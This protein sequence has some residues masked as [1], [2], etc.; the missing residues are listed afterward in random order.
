MDDSVAS[1]IGMLEEL[2]DEQVSGDV[3]SLNGFKNNAVC[4]DCDGQ[5][6]SVYNVDEGIIRFRSI[7]DNVDDACYEVYNRLRFC[8][9]D[10]ESLDVEKFRPSAG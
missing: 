2:L 5:E 6:Y 10:D 7:F 3:F 4:L 1:C 9:D 8:F